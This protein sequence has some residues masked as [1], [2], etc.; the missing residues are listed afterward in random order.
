[1]FKNKI[2]IF[3]TAAIVIVVVAVSG[4]YIG[5]RAGRNIPLTIQVQGVSNI[6]PEASSTADFG[7][8]WQTWQ[9]INN[10]YLN[11]SSTSDQSKVYGAINGLVDSLNDPYSEFFSPSDSQK[12]QE[13]VQGSFSGIGAQ[14]DTKNGPIIIAA[15]IKDSP[16]QKAGLKSGDQ[17]VGIDGTS[18]VNMNLNDA[19]KLIRGENNTPV[20]LTI[21]RS[22]WDKPRD[23]K[24]IRADIQVPTLD[25]S[26]KDGN[27]AYIHLYAFNANADLLFY[28]AI[29][30]AF[31][32]GARG[33]VLD[34]RDNPGGYLQTAVDLS[35]WFLHRGS[36]VVTEEGRNLKDVFRANGN[37][38]LANFPTVVI[39]NG[40]SA[41]AAEILSGALHDDR[42][43]KL[44]GEQSFGKGT[45][46][47]MVSLSGGSS[48][49][50]TIAHWV[51][52]DGQILEGHGL[53]PD[54]PVKLTDNDIKNKQ[55]P[56]LDKA[57]ELI[58]SEIK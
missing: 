38:A 8:F 55:D 36:V 25:Y 15:P 4:I 16:A 37:E 7:P 30:K 48:I 24:I 14:L 47:E 21:L 53:I 29:I 33:L 44:V 51:L 11:N 22:N 17:I 43:I 58:K 54:V 39:I 42:G 31:N 32:G 5:W 56:Q 6:G 35:G 45:V 1:M 49:K 20:T 46:Q 23:F 18:T 40:G 34:L 10:D 28:Q 52:P 9:L 26:M 41:S 13:D 57:L 19:V 3:V 27:I 12:F 50:L 2:F